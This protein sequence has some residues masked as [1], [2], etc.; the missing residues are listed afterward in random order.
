MVNWFL[1]GMVDSEDFS[2]FRHTEERPITFEKRFD[3]VMVPLMQQ[4]RLGKPDLIVEA[5]LRTKS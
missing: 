3:E 2:W 4:E 1:Y 5:S